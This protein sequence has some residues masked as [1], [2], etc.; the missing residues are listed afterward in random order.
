MDVSGDSLF[1]TLVIAIEYAIDGFGMGS[2]RDH[3]PYET[4]CITC[5][6]EDSRKL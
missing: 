1:L 3:M 5:V 6:A 2:K 4:V